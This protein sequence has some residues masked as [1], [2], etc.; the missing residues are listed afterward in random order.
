MNAKTTTAPV[1]TPAEMA[2]ALR[3][4]HGIITGM[5][6]R[7]ELEGYR[8]GRRHWRITLAEAQRKFPAVFGQGA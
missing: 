1:L 7:G 8:V 6:R 5:L 4:G 2:K 3:V